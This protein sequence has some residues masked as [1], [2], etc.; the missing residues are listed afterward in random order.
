MCGGAAGPHRRRPGCARGPGAGAFTGAFGIEAGRYGR[1]D[2]GIDLRG[3]SIETR[4]VRSYGVYAHNLSVE[5]GGNVSVRTGGGHVIAAAGAEAHGILARTFG[6]SA[7]AGAI[8]I[9]VGGAVTAGGA[10]ARGIAVGE[11][12]DTDVVIDVSEIIALSR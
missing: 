7:G 11:V 6:T 9:D 4:G 8:V 2:I 12:D 3:G 5:N 10:D 1:G